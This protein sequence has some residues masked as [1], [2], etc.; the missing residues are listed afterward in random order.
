MQILTQFAVV[1][2]RYQTRSFRKYLQICNC[3]M[4]ISRPKATSR[5]FRNVKGPYTLTNE[6]AGYAV[7]QT[8]LFNAETELNLVDVLLLY[9]QCSL[10]PAVL[11]KL[12]FL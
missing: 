5:K 8:I 1:C 4:S 7:I 10:L 11:P 3:S 2:C 12:R 6:T 9:L